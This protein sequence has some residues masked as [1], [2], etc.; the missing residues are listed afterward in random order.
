MIVPCY[1]LCL[2]VIVLCYFLY[3]K[4]IVP[5]YLLYLKVIVPLLFVIL[6]SNS[7]LLRL[8]VRITSSVQASFILQYVLSKGTKSQILLKKLIVTDVSKT[9]EFEGFDRE[10]CPRCF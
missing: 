9:A 10:F 2:K 7:S 6:E 5:C 8:I 4:V 1:F 3:L